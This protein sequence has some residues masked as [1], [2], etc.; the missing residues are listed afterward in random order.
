VRSSASETGHHASAAVP[1]LR[2]SGERY[3]TRLIKRTRDRRRRGL[4]QS[5]EV[6]AAVKC[7]H[8]QVRRRLAWRN[9][10]NLLEGDRRRR[11][12]RRSDAS[13]PAATPSRRRL[14]TATNHRYDQARHNAVLGP[15][16]NGRYSHVRSALARA[17]GRGQLVPSITHTALP[18]TT[19]ESASV[20][21]NRLRSFP[22]S[23]EPSASAS[24]VL[25]HSRRN[26]A[27]KLSRT[28]VL[29]CGA[30]R[31]ASSSSNRLS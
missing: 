2:C 21:A 7:H 6:I 29:R 27:V 13:H 26:A 8:R 4:C 30:V 23:T 5:L 25:G 3:T 1:D 17:A 9:S 10:G 14:R 28:N 18:P 11:L 31:A 22:T 24:H 12:R 19:A 16:G 20:V 15:R